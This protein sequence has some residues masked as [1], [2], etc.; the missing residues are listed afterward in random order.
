MNGL[1]ANSQLGLLPN[2]TSSSV[3]TGHFILKGLFSRVLSKGSGNVCSSDLTRKA[4]HF[5]EHAL[6]V[7]KRNE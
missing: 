3:W 7:G 1:V 2:C 4:F 6:Q 5:L